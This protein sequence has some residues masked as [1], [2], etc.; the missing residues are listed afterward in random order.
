M[1]ILVQLKNGQDQ[2]HLFQDTYFESSKRHQLTIMYPFEH[3]NHDILQHF[4]FQHLYKLFL[5]AHLYIN[6][7]FH[8]YETIK[9]LFFRQ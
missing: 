2:V 6:N 5:C 1:L 3:I 8:G 7:V 9:I 4:L